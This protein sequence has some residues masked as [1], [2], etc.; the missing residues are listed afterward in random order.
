MRY[1]LLSVILILATFN[2]AYAELA[3]DEQASL[4][5]SVDRRFDSGNVL[6]Y[7]HNEC[8]VFL[9]DD[10]GWLTVEAYNTDWQGKHITQVTS[11]QRRI[12]GGFLKLSYTVE[13]GF[14][15]S[16]H[17]FAIDTGGYDVFADK[18]IGAA[19]NLPVEVKN[20]F[21]GF[22]GLGEE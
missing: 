22:Y 19:E 14:K 8:T 5:W 9:R 3:V 7:R 11:I 13:T 16:G 6:R 21:H 1:L 15:N 2:S 20:E 4:E 17:I 18:C 12:I 10:R